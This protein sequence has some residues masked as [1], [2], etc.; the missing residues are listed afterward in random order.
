M[1]IRACEIVPEEIEAVRTG[2]NVDGSVAENE[3]VAVK[4]SVST[5]MM[6]ML[7]NEQALSDD[8]QEGDIEDNKE[9]IDEDQLKSEASN[10]G[11]NISSTVADSG[12]ESFPPTEYSGSSIK[13][14]EQEEEPT[15]YDFD[16]DCEEF[17]KQRIV[18]HF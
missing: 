3:I 13:Q 12:R 1:K 2:D 7:L 9:D 4:P 8:E 10:E 18:S 11:G 16:E 6:T 15:I 14:E 17:E 5:S